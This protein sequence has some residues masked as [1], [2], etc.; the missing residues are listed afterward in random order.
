MK[1]MITLSLAL[2]ACAS[3]PRPKQP[4]ARQAVDPLRT[5]GPATVYQLR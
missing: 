4:R 2:I 5:C 1:R 3:T